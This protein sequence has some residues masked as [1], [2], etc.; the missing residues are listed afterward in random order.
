MPNLLWANLINMYQPPNCDRVE[1]EQIVNK[2]YIPLLKIFSQN[3]DYKF[4]LN[5]PGST[6]ELLIRTG[7]GQV[8]KKIAELADRGQVDFTATPKYQPMMPF[9]NDED[10][11]RQIEAGNKICRRYFGISYVP[12]GL[13]SPFLAYSQSVAKTTARFGLKWAVTDEITFSNGNQSGFSL[14]FMDKSAGGVILI[15]RH[16]ELSDQLEGNIYAR[17]LPRTA[18][19]FIQSVL[20]KCSS[21]KYF[22]TV[23]NA[24][25]FGYQNPG[26]HGLLKALYGE[27]KLKRTTISDLR[28]FIRRKEFVKA[29]EGSSE[30]RLQD[31]KRRKPFISWQNENNIIQHT[32][33]QLFNLA[34]AE[35][36]NAATKGDPQYVRAREMF[37]SA[38][39]GVNWLMASGSP[40]WNS[41][42]P[43]QAA[44]DLAI[45]VFVLLSSPLKAKENAIAQR[46]KL[47]ADI[48]QFEKSGEIKKWQKNYLRAN[49]IPLERFLN[50][51]STEQ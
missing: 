18:A 2:S 19:E 10:V 3:P 1:L 50:K 17:K 8:I 35:I 40:W 42:Y 20:Q 9:L 43:L 49:N 32:L 13:Y 45:A 22:A 5:I 36:K 33:W 26:R 41:A 27:P 30:T 23:I 38:S 46:Q 39:A 29:T 37:D 15:P 6:V 51:P 4:S 28:S 24:E 11:D 25:W 47:Y 14:L 7:F 12:K 44:D 31:Y 21:D 34:A 48:E 16:R